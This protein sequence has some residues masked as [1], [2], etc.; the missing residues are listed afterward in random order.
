MS[1]GTAC[2]FQEA[3]RK[4]LLDFT[5]QLESLEEAARLSID[6]LKSD[7]SAL[8]TRVANVSSLVAHANS[9]LQLQMKDFLLSAQHRIENIK[10]QIERLEQVRVNL[11]TFLC[12]DLETFKLEECFKYVG[13][14][15]V[16]R[17]VRR[18]ERDRW[19]QFM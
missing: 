2:N 17:L 13:Q 14:S 9:D 10:D 16:K 6:T 5:D 11:G 8:T 15:K 19:Q 18:S 12:E 3:E 1:K 7:A 4:Q